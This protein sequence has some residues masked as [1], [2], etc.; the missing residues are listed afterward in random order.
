MQYDTRFD[1]VFTPLFAARAGINALIHVPE[2][3]V[4]ATGC[5]EGTVKV[6]Q[7]Q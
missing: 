1:V 4:V 2:M 6:R 3:G 7:H 5:D